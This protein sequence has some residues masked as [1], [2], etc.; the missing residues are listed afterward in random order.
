M[1]NR[2][3]EKDEVWQHNVIGLE[4]TPRGQ[5][6]SMPN[7]LLSPSRP[8][9]VI[10]IARLPRVGRD[11]PEVRDA[12]EQAAAEATG[13]VVALLGPVDAVADGSS[14]GR[15]VDAELVEEVTSTRGEGVVEVVARCGQLIVVGGV[16]VEGAVAAGHPA[17]IEEGGHECHTEPPCE[18]VVAG[19]GAA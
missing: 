2:S 7:V 4:T 18:V 11:P 10:S 8:A 13:E 14:A 19:A 12:D 5:P 9:A 17:A 15:E 6:K 1:P 3:G 16:G